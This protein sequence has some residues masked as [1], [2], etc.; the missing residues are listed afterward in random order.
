MRPLM[1]EIRSAFT[2]RVAT[3]MAELYVYNQAWRAG[4]IPPADV[5]FRESGDQEVMTMPSR[6][7]RRK[8]DP[9]GNLV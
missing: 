6:V 2:G 4:I 3:D 7:P 9:Q 1:V 8:F 5:V